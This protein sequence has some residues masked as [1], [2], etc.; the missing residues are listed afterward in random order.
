MTNKVI[1]R[2][3]IRLIPRYA[4]PHFEKLSTGSGNDV[5]EI[6]MGNDQHVH[7]NSPQRRGDTETLKNIR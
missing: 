6:V 3:I 2:K 4:I 5:V 7:E 1:G